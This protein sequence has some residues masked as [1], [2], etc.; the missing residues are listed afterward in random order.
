MGRQRRCS[1]H[2]GY[3]SAHTFCRIPASRPPAIG[4]GCAAVCISRSKPPAKG[5]HM[6]AALAVAEILKREGVEFIIGYPVNTILEAAAQADI[7]PIIVRQERTGLHMADAV[8]RV[9]SGERIG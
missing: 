1:R 6:K 4:P 3:E 7:R 9:A 5:E 2:A 8:S